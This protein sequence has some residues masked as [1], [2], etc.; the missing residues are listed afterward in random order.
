[1][2]LLWPLAAV[3]DALVWR[4][5]RA[6]LGGRSKLIISGGSALPKFLERF[7]EAAGIHIVS[8]YGLTE[9]SPVIAVRRADKNLVDG[10]V[11][12]LPPKEV[13]LQIRDP[14]THAP[15][16]PGRPGVVFTRGPQVMLGYYKEG[17]ATAKVLDADGWFE[18]GDLGLINPGTGDLVLT[19][20]CM[21]ACG[22]EGGWMGGGLIE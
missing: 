16:P 9:T 10:G 20:A 1:M 15:L 21:F 5:V 3:A 13:E 4:K 18:T 8:G 17:A 11:V 12:G 14:E 19:G 7:Y 22:W 2:P 6:A